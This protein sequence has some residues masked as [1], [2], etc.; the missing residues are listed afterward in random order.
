MFHFSQD[1]DSDFVRDAIQCKPSRDVTPTALVQGKNRQ[2]PV[3][4]VA[5]PFSSGNHLATN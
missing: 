1:L 3:V 5:I 4:Q 2:K